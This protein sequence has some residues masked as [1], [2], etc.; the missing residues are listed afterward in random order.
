MKLPPLSLDDAMLDN[1]EAALKTCYGGKDEDGN[2]TL[3]GGDFTLHQLLDF[4]SGYDKS[5]LIFTGLGD[6]MG[7]GLQDAPIYEY[8]DPMYHP[9]DL[10][11]ALITEVRK[12]RAASGSNDEQREEGVA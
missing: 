4:Y 8:P 1:V 12:L 2:Q 5:K 9:N 10:I 11:R 6:P 3:V 7:L